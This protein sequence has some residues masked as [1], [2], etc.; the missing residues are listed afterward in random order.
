[1][2]VQR[3]ITF[4]MDHPSQAESIWSSIQADLGEYMRRRRLSG[5]RRGVRLARFVGTAMRAASAGP[6]ESG[7]G[8]PK[9]G[10]E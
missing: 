8:A 3:A 1:M 4:M 5:T 9:T 7:P 2:C 6:A 10:Q